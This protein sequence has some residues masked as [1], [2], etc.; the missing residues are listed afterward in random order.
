MKH[1]LLVEAKMRR[2]PLTRFRRRPRRGR[3]ESRSAWLWLAIALLVLP[4]HVG[5]QTTRVSVR[6]DGTQ[7][8]SPSS[9]VAISGD[10]R[11][12]AF[13]SGAANLV[14]GDTNG[15]NDV[16]VYDRLTSTTTRVSVRTDGGEASGSSRSAALSGDGR[17]VA[18][19]SAS[20]NLVPNDSNG[21]P[22][23]FVHDRAT[24]TTTRVSVTSSGQ[25][26]SGPPQSPIQTLRC[27]LSADGRFV[28]FASEHNDL[29][30]GDTNGKRDIFLHDRQTGTT[31][32]I[33]VAS[34]GTEAVGDFLGSDRP[35]MSGDGRY[36]VYRSDAM[37]LVPDG[38]NNRVHIYLYDHQT[39]V[40]TRVSVRTAGTRAGA[41]SFAPRISAD[42]RVV[43]FDSEDSMG[44]PAENLRHIY[45]R[46]LMAGVTTRVS[47]APNGALSQGPFGNMGSFDPSVSRDGRFV[48]FHSATSNLVPGDTNGTGDVF[49]HDRVTARTVRASV[50]SS[51]GQGIGLSQG[52]AV[53]ADGRF[54]A[55]SSDAA[56]LVSGDTNSGSDVFVRDMRRF[57][58]ERVSVSASGEQLAANVLN[59]PSVSGDGRTV[60]FATNAPAAPGDTN[61]LSDVYVRDLVAKTTTRVSVATGG[62][63]GGGG[64]AAPAISA[65]GA[66]VAFMSAAGSLVPGDTNGVADV[67]VHERSS[68]TTSRVSVSSAGVEANGPSGGPVLSGD[69]SVVAFA[70]AASNLV[71]DDSNGRWDVFVHERATGRTS[72][73]S[74]RSGDVQSTGQIAPPRLAISGDGSVVAYDSEAADLV[75]GDTN[76]RRDVFVHD[77]DTGFTERVSLASNG[78]QA[79]G[80]ASLGPSLNQNGRFVAFASDAINLVP[81]DFAGRRDVFV[82]DRSTGATRRVSRPGGRADGPVVTPDGR[83]VAFVQAG[84]TNTPF[85]VAVRDVVGPPSAMPRLVEAVLQR[86]SATQVAA[87]ADARL[88]VFLSAATDIVPDDTNGAV[89]VF[90][91][92]VRPIVEDV[93]PR[94]G[95]SAGG[96]AVEIRGSGFVPGTT[97]TIGGVEATAVTVVDATRITAVTPPGTAGLVDV[98]V[99]VPGVDSERLAWSFTYQSS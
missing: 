97:I 63:D 25:Q 88:I 8:V 34:D 9:T 86:T 31:T 84:A 78:A 73:V 27:A 12:V 82:R 55:F 15:V 69:G 14:A 76:G 50:S 7:A 80:G 29:V 42:G 39:A 99:S 32:R 48:T 30:P 51:G 43:V 13:E 46:D 95:P 67:F 64:S 60:A 35:T 33:N 57:V 70:S 71:A 92:S 96:T 54:V 18:F 21:L 22:D 17:F 58:H 11:H 52:G 90:A 40:T 20:A 65:D 53:S 37:N 91:W 45:V 47:M 66:V 38:S 85:R 75:A 26:A 4:A 72:R 2:S 56:N 1:G 62:A 68:A 23:L 77:R 94:S 61:T 98:V 24:G 16:F 10:G 81:Q 5:A 93:V 49:L 87:S 28:V 83:F 44:F 59:R 41:D 3:S 89:D 74:V 6:S 19:S 79:A 36:I